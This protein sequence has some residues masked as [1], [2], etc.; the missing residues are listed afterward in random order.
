MLSAELLMEVCASLVEEQSGKLIRHSSRKA[1]DL[2]KRAQAVLAS[3]V[4]L[5]R[6][7]ELRIK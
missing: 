6:P 4:S 2:R 3:I 7:F 1:A 5:P